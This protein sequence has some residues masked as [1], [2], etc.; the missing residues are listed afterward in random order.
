MLNIVE[1]ETQ[2]SSDTNSNN[3]ITPFLFRFN[4]ILFSG[5]VCEF[6]SDKR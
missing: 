5:N 4:F 6:V 1:W 2:Q 3:E